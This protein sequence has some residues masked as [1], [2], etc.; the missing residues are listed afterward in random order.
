MK[1]AQY[2]IEQK[3]HPRAASFNGSSTQRFKQ[4]F[5]AP[6]FEVFGNRVGEDGLEGLAVLSLHRKM[7]SFFDTKF[8]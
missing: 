4:G 3:P 8:N 5:D 2:S 7:T 6:P 1:C